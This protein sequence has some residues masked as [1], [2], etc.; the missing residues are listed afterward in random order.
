LAPSPVIVES[1]EFGP[2]GPS[3]SIGVGTNRGVFEAFT[4]NLTNWISFAAGADTFVYSLNFDPVNRVLVRERWAAAHSSSIRRRRDPSPTRTGH[5][6]RDA[7]SNE[8]RHAY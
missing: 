8:N 6:N 3:L 7:Y 2:S 4:T 1:I 5:S